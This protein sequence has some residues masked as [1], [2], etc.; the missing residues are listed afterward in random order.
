MSN[1]Y[2]G[3]QVSIVYKTSTEKEK[4]IVLLSLTMQNVHGTT[5]AHVHRQSYDLEADHVIYVDCPT[6]RA[7]RNRV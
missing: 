4:V 5:A 3:L 1:T 2:L 7:V 6:A